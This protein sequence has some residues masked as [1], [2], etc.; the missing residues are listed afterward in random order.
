MIESLIKNLNQDIALLQLR[1]ERDKDAGFYDMARLLETISIQFFKALGIASLKSKNQIK[2]NFPAIDAADD[3]KD[4]GIAVQ[5]TSVADAK[6]IKKTI[7]TYEKKDGAGKCLKDGYATLYIFGFCKASTDATV[8]S[9]CQVVGPGFFVDRLIDLDDEERVQ[10][11][12]D[13][14]RRHVD[15]SS[16]HPYDDIECLK[17]ALGYMGRN[18]VRHR[19]SCEGN[20]N[21]MTKGLKEIS[22]LIGKGTVNGKQKSKAHHEFEDQEI[23]EFLRHVLNEIG[24]ITAIVNRANRDGFVYLNNH[25]MM[26]IDHRKRS[27]TTLA[28]RI[29]AKHGIAMPLDMHEVD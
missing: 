17:I 20:I 21:D 13:S 4:G 12:I 27:I 22:E 8:P 3:D 29:A 19:M 7:E 15:Y 5:V 10:A 9:Y 24:S 11:V 25:D 18:A 2:V 14:V 28:Q 1:I 6:K 23:G 16:I 26:S